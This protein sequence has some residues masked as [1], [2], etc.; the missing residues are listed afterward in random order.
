MRMV[1]TVTSASVHGKELRAGDQFDCTDKDARLW[2][3]L[4]RAKHVEVSDEKAQAPMVEQSKSED[5][6][7]TLRSRYLEMTGRD[8]D[9]RWGVNKLKRETLSSGTYGRRDMRAED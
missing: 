1:V 8:A 4:G 5:D 9:L 2:V 7:D 3:A 6:I